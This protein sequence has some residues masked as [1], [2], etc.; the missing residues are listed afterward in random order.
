M[1]RALASATFAPPVP[2]WLVLTQA[3]ASVLLALVQF[4]QPGVDHLLTL[5]V[6]LGCYWLLWAVLELADLALTRQGWFWRLAAAAAGLAAAFVVLREP[7]WSTFLL[8]AAI[9]SVMGWYALGA[10]ALSLV[11]M[12]AGGGRGAPILGTQSLVLGVVLLHG[13]PEVTEWG[14]AAVAFMGGLATLVF[15]LRGQLVGP[16]EQARR[17]RQL[18]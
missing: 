11:R 12:L 6:L 8:P 5:L 13:A 9:A 17:S 4:T 1:M 14:G 10:G 2:S 15:A 3:I 18:A 16:G 7:L